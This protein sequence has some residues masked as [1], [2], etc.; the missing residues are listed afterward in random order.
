[1]E[2]SISLLAEKHNSEPPFQLTDIYDCHLPTY[3]LHLR[4]F[5]CIAHALIS[6]PERK[7]TYTI[8]GVL[9]TIGTLLSH[10]HTTY[11]V[12][13]LSQRLP[14]SRSPTLHPL[15]ANSSRTQFRDKN[16]GA[17]AHCGAQHPIPV[18]WHL[19]LKP[20]S[21]LFSDATRQLSEKTVF[22]QW[23]T[24]PPWKSFHVLKIWRK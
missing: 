6:F 10:S 22:L 4:F 3:D 7:V 2:C 24:A 1:M 17:A 13:I 11:Y 14:A 21:P 19:K 20:I 8:M 15:S 9:F 23:R 16:T 12:G 5:F 18:L